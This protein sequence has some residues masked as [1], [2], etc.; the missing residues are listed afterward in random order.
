MSAE[1]VL[2]VVLLVVVF[3]LLIGL[4]SLGGIA[5][6]FM[7]ARQKPVIKAKRMAY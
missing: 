1:L 5:S 2:L 6:T 3:M 7:L 4:S